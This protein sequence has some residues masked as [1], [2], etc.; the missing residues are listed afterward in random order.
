MP[1]RVL[2]DLPQ[3][4]PP[5][6]KAVLCGRVGEGN[7]PEDASAGFSFGFGGGNDSFADDAD[8]GFGED[9]SDSPDSDPDFDAGEGDGTDGGTSAQ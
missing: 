3:A 1:Q 2:P 5:D 8:G 9:F 7:P 4:H 6:L